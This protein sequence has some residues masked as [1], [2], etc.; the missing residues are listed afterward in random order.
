MAVGE[1]GVGKSTFLNALFE[2]GI[3][4][5][6][7]ASALHDSGG[8]G[9]T[10]TT[11]TT[12]Q[13]STVELIENGVTLDLTVVDTPGFAAA[14]N[15]QDCWTAITDDI[16]KAFEG[17]MAAESK[18]LRSP[19]VQDDRVH[20]CLYFINPTGHGLKPLDAVVMQKLHN[21]VNLIPVIGKADLLTSIELAAFKSRIKEEI[22]SNGIQL[23]TFPNSI[24]PDESAS[25]TSQQRF[26]Q[27]TA[28]KEDDMS[29]S[30]R[31]LVREQ[32]QQMKDMESQLLAQHDTLEQK[33]K[34]KQRDLERK[35]KE[36]QL[37]KEA[38]IAARTKKTGSKGSLFK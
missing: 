27:A 35:R 15:N 26:E 28:Q 11:T 1:S 37:E 23:Y 22:E 10:D 16:D 2:S 5:S 17:Y 36:F 8:G 34:T 6:T 13:R 12:V 9:S 20:C 21:K 38:Y 31:T 24:D 7:G 33:L 3:F 18:V 4:S 25:E 19:V 30:F 14:V 32:E 29:A